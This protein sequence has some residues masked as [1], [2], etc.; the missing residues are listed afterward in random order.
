MALADQ[1]FEAVGEAIEEFPEWPDK[2]GRPARLLIRPLTLQGA[3][4]IRALGL[5]DADTERLRFSS[6][7]PRPDHLA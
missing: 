2:K 7:I 1:I 6:R 5:K 3:E 4:Q